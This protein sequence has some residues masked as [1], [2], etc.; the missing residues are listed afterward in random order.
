VSVPRAGFV[1]G[2][3]EQPARAKRQ[4]KQQYSK[5]CEYLFEQIAT[6]LF[7]FEN[8]VILRNNRH[9]TVLRLLNAL[10]NPRALNSRETA[11]PALQLQP[12]DIFN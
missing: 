4:Q 3:R 5:C 9:E 6:P 1:P 11:L 8:A 7:G 10:Y 12:R 2:I